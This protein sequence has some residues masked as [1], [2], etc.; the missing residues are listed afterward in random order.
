M[1]KTIRQ[2]VF[3]GIVGVITLIVDVTVTYALFHF[4]HFPAFLASG[5]GFLSGFLFNFPMNRKQ[6]FRHN[7][8]DRFSLKA[9][10]ILYATLSVFNL[11]ATSMAVDALVSSDILPIQTAKI[12][13]TA[14]FAIWNFLV[15]KLFI[16]SKKPEGS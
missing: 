2:I 11:F 14:L 12:V 10:I 6:V 7:D 8:N 4:A 9:Q 5:V 16:F 15:F 1:V 13:I 3:F